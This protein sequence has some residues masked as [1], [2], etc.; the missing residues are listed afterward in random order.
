MRGGN[1]KNTKHHTRE[2]TQVKHVVWFAGSWEKFLDNSLVHV[3]RCLDK[4]LQ[5]EQNV[6]RVLFKPAEVIWR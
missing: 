3:H 6:K 2:V 5:K 1:E 4:N